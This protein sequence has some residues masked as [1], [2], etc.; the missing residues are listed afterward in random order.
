MGKLGSMRAKSKPNI[1]KIG[2]SSITPSK[3]IKFHRKEAV[4]SLKKNDF[5]GYRY[6]SMQ[7]AKINT[8]L[9]LSRMKAK[10]KM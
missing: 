7:V 4:L 2:M 5:R 8:G 9:V 6:H 10:K 3:K 1:Y